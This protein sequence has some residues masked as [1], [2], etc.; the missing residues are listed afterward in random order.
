MNAQKKPDG[1]LLEKPMDY[2]KLLETV[3]TVLAEPPEVRLAR[4]AGHQAD[5]HYLAPAGRPIQQ[6]PI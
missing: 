1:A 3:R 5:F 4:L 6:Y 2:S